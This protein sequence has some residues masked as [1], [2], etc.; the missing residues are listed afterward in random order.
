MRGYGLLSDYG[1][2]CILALVV[3]DMIDE[4]DLPMPITSTEDATLPTLRTTK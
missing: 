3:W 4:E 1:S 2:S